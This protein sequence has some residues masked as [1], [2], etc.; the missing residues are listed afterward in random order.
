MNNSTT[1]PRKND[2]FLA[3]WKD[4]LK[5]ELILGIDDEAKFFPAAVAD[6]SL[7]G[8]AVRADLTQTLRPLVAVLRILDQ[9]GRSIL[10]AAGRV[11]WDR[12]TTMTTRTLGLK[13]RR[14][15][16]EPLLEELVQE[17]WVSRREL[18][19]ESLNCPIGVRR[20]AG[21]TPIEKATLADRSRTGVRL[22]TDQPLEVGERVLVTL[23]VD[24]EGKTPGGMVAIVWSRETDERSE[25]GAVYLNLTSGHT[26]NDADLLAL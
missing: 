8:C 2:R 17:G 22:I 20:T 19:R 9:S 23:P 13:F 26:I 10:E 1:Q 24:A 12:Q 21:K 4:A 3:D 6:L 5:A 18:P 15:L 7:T 14:S 16:P 11:C 25:A